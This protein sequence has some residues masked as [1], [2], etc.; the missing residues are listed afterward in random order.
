MPVKL[1]QALFADPDIMLL[2]E[3]TNNLDINTILSTT[4]ENLRQTLSLPE[5]S[6]R[7]SPPEGEP[8]SNGR[9][10]EELTQEID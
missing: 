2:D 9:Q 3:P 5:L 8:A 10:D 6:I 4:A 7:M 1:A